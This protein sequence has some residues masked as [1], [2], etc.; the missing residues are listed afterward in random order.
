M[1]KLTIYLML[2]LAVLVAGCSDLPD[3]QFEKYAIIVKNGYHEWNLPYNGES[4]ITSY[5]SIAVSGTSIISEDMVVNIEIKPENLEAYNFDKFRY[6]TS[7]YYELLPDDCYEIDATEVV[8]KAGEEYGLLPVRFK[9]DKMDKYLNYILPIEITSVSRYSIGSNDYNKALINVVLKNDYSGMYSRTVDLSSTEGGM[10]ITGEQ[11]LRTIT[12]NTCYFTVA[13]LDKQSE[14]KDYHINMVINADS[15]LTLSAVNPDIEFE[16][17]TPNKEKD[18]ETNI[19]E[20]KEIG[21]KS[22]SMKFFL[23]Y[24]YMDKSN[25]EAN[26]VRRNIKGFLIREIREE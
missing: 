24:S 18:Q 1:K 11:P 10:L 21:K 25:P 6:D 15:T 19:V 4:E 17:A 20:I 2:C 14:S 13:Y 5:I 8:V 23:N 26:P 16:F 12:P 3:E 7:S 9:I 22:K